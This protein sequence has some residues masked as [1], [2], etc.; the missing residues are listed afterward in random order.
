MTDRQ[1]DRVTLDRVTDRQR[2]GG[3]QQRE[4]ETEVERHREK[5]GLS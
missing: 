2:G 5:C 1:S 4:T 3:G